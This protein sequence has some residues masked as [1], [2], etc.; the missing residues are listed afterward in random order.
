MNSTSLA[1][2]GILTVVLV[3][4]AVISW[5]LYVRSKG[6]DTSYDDD[7]ALWS[8]KRKRVYEPMDKSTVFIGSSRIKFDLDIDTWETMTG[9]LPVQQR[10]LVWAVTPSRFWKTWLLMKISKAN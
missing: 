9:D 7:P 4:A 5:E 10:W 8:D 6:Y 2:A 3:A 1:K